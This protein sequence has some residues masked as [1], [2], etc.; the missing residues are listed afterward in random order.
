[1]TPWR[2]YDRAVMMAWK[3]YVR[4]WAFV[5]CGSQMAGRLLPAFQPACARLFCGAAKR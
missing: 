2:A 3:T 4:L 1:M 5:P